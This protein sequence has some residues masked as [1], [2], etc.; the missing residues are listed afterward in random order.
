MRDIFIFK[1]ALYIFIMT[2]YLRNVSL[3]FTRLEELREPDFIRDYQLMPYWMS[4]WEPLFTFSIYFLADPTHELMLFVCL[5]AVRTCV[6]PYHPCLTSLSCKYRTYVRTSSTQ[7]CFSE[8]I[9]R[10]LCANSVIMNS[11]CIG[12]RHNWYE[13]HVP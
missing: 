1:F 9:P 5:S 2:E 11:S 13:K 6:Q 8:P 4:P 3:D 10:S 12:G 7:S